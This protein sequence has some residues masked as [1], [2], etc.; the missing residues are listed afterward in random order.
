METLRERDLGYSYAFRHPGVVLTPVVNWACKRG[1][2]VNGNGY[3]MKVTDTLHFLNLVN[4]TRT[5][6]ASERDPQ[7][8]RKSKYDPLD[9]DAA[10]AKLPSALLLEPYESCSRCHMTVPSFLI[11][12]GLIYWLLPQIDHSEG[13]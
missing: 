9:L 11:S 13:T 10:D 5:Q 7:E 6:R 8:H 1:H 3:L 12:P 4:S 2:L